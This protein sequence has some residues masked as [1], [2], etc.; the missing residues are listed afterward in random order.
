M[1][2]SCVSWVLFGVGLW[3]SVVGMGFGWFCAWFGW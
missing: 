1:V 2:D 3:R